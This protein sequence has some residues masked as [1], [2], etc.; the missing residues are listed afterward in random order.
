[1][2]ARAERR[3]NDAFTLGATD[4]G[5][6]VRNRYNSAINFDDPDDVLAILQRSIWRLLVDRLGLQQFLSI[7]AAKQ[8]DEQL[9]TGDL[10]PLTADN[11]VTM[12]DGF[13][14]QIPQMLEAS[15][16]EVFDWLTPQARWHNYKT[17]SR[18]TVGRKVIVTRMVSLDS[19]SG[20]R[21][22]YGGAEDHLSALENVFTSLDGKG[23][24]TKTH[25]SAISTAIK[26]A[27][28]A[29]TCEGETPYFKFRGFR[30]GNLHITFKRPDLVKRFNQIAG[31]A[32]LTPAETETP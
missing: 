30:N 22:C 16:R 13:R 3:L 9:R 19:W 25:Y 11:V 14:Q 6:G 31:G 29:E 21:V 10:P 2:V 4:G 8:L 18:F 23:C 1:M 24:V 32:R 28:K 15:V 5:I 20:W 27:P 12:A 7:S 17:N 26:A